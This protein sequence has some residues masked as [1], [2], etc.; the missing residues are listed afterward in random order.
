MSDKE[1]ISQQFLNYFSQTNGKAWAPLITSITESP[2]VF[3][4]NPFL[5]NPNFKKV[6]SRPQNFSSNDQAPKTEQ[7]KLR[8]FT[9]FKNWSQVKGSILMISIHPT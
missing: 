7:A 4:F 2:L 1:K 3:H 8:M 6:R 5:Q 9:T